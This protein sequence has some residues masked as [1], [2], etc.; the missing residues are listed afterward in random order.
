MENELLGRAGFW[1]IAEV[2]RTLGD[3]FPELTAA[4]W[5][6]ESAWGRSMSGTNNPFG[7][8]GIPGIDDV[9]YR[10]TWE[11]INGETIIT[12]EPFMNY[13]SLYHALQ[14]RYRR[15]I[16]KYKDAQTIE[17]AIDILLKNRYATDPDYKRKILAIIDVA[18]RNG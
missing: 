18:R 9:T 12:D 14:D 10:K 8:K 4:Q 11:V 5:A 7:Q 17:E 15:W 1:Q 6:L 16:V 3:P 2:S 13:E